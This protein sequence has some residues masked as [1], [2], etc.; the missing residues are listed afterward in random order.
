[1]P[2]I[3]PTKYVSIQTGARL[4]GVARLTLRDAIKSGRVQGIE[5]DGYYFALRSSCEKF[6]RD[7]V[8]R[9]RPTS[10][11]AP[12][13]KARPRRWSAKAAAA[14]AAGNV[15]PSK[16]MSVGAAAKVCNVSRYWMRKLVQEGHV[17]GL[18]IEGQVFPLRSAVEAYAENPAG[19]GRPRG[20]SHA[21]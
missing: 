14:P 13:G 7:P 11:P 10:T 17:R 16:Y 3:D 2:T 1:M 12:T 20:G 6:E 4:A 18:Q 15:D 9:G 21:S 19:T 8:G 5:I